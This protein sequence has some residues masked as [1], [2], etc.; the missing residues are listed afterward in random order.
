MP[1][2]N[3][4]TCGAGFIPADAEGNAAEAWAFGSAGRH[5]AGPTRD[6]NLPSIF[7]NPQ[8]KTGARRLPFSHLPNHQ[9][10]LMVVCMTVVCVVTV[11]ALAW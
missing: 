5:K 2:Y 7:R 10:M 6:R 8:T 9:V 11:L 4:E 3:R 1:N